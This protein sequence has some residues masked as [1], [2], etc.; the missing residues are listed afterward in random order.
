MAAYVYLLQE[1]PHCPGESGPWTKI[2]YSKNPPE[3][4]LEANLKRGN[5]RDLKL[6]R[7]YEFE[8]VRAAREA[9]RSAH[10]QF[11]QVEHQKEWFQ[12]RWQRVANWCSKTGFKV[13]DS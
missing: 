5:P 12:L 2:G 11:R 6:A 13:R 7:I 4:R 1:I 3:W 9:E 8:S 10:N